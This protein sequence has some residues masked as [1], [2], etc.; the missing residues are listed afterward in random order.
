MALEILS[1]AET[2]LV[3]FCETHEVVLGIAAV[4]AHRILYLSTYVRASAFDYK[5][6]SS[7]A[8]PNPVEV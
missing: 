3:Y 1:I 5:L 8:I 7:H 4:L 6:K 2:Y